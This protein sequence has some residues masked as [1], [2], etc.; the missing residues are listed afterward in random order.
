MAGTTVFTNGCFDILHA[1]HVRLLRWARAQGDRLLVGLNS[2]ESVRRLKGPDRPIFRQ[3]D[4]RTVLGALACVDR[5]I[6]FDEDTPVRLLRGLR[7]HILVKG[8]ECAGQ[9]IP[10]QQFIESIGGRVAIPN[11]EV[12][13][14][15]TDTIHRIMSL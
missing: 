12:A 3:Q 5:V 14:S 2:D 10:G 8:P 6:I 15:T 13:M 11:W 9:P 1:E 7:P 4:R